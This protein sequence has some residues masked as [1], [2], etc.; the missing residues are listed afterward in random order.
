MKL[1]DTKNPYFLVLGKGMRSLMRLWE[2]LFK[3][4]GR[5]LHALMVPCESKRPGSPGLFFNTTE[6]SLHRERCSAAAGRRGVGDGDLEG[7]TDEFFDVVDF[8]SLKEAQ[9]QRIDNHT[10]AFTLKDKIII[11]DR[12]VEIESILK[13]R[14]APTADGHS[15]SRVRLI[16]LLHEKANTLCGALAQSHGSHFAIVHV[17]SPDLPRTILIQRSMYVR[18][19]N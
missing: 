7:G 19:L 11:G 13:S 3:I 9:G 16:F 17:C 1:I 12:A 10:G 18:N 5:D 2:T 8:G 6:R 15:D 14:A 4:T